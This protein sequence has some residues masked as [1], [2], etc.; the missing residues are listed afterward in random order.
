[1]R[2][3]VHHPSSESSNRRSGLGPIQPLQ[4]G[5]DPSDSLNSTAATGARPFP[6]QHPSSRTVEESPSLVTTTRCSN[7]PCSSGRW[8][9]TPTIRPPSGGMMMA[10]LLAPRRG[11]RAGYPD[12]GGPAAR[13]AGAGG[14]PRPASGTPGLP[15]SY[16]LQAG[17]PTGVRR[18]RH[19]PLAP[20]PRLAQDPDRHG[21]VM[22]PWWPG[23]AQALLPPLRRVFLQETQPALDRLAGLLGG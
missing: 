19:P 18:G 2:N 12:A 17:R 11:Q 3:W 4:G 15:R 1:M 20:A 9:M 8:V 7:S 23:G 21:P 10:L 13:E 16:D 6:V 14:V 5:I 22:A